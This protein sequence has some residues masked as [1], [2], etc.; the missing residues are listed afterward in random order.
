MKSLKLILATFFFLGILSCSKES[1]P[2]NPIDDAA[3]ATSQICNDV[4]GVEAIYW[5]IFNGVARGDIPGGI[6]LL[7]NPGNQF[8]H[9]GYPALGFTMPVG[10]TAHQIGGNSVH[11]I[12]VN[13]LRND[14]LVLWRYANVS[15][16]GITNAQEILQQEINTFVSALGSPGNVQVVCNNSSSQPQ[17]SAT[18][19]AAT[20]MIRSGNSTAYFSANVY[21]SPNLGASF[22]G[23]QVAG[24]P[25]AE[26]E[27]L[28][29]ETFLPITWQL[30]YTGG[31]SL[32]DSDGDGEPDATD[33]D[34]FD[35]NV[36]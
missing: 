13:V 18:I 27:N 19:T 20:A 5:D 16:F 2:T 30:L 26:I 7:T 32:L 35:P 33:A 25:T 3:N 31:N 21:T 6:P 15:F 14:N 4:R 23:V 17:G 36:Q 12:G 24:G 9:S 11:E 29:L 10:Y 34:P 22:I 8:I 1:E 28:I